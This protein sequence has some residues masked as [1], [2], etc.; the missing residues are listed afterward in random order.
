MIGVFLRGTH[1]SILAVALLHTMFNRSNNDEGLVAG[2]LEGD[3]RKLAGLLAVLILTATI[4]YI[5]RRLNRPAGTDRDSTI[6]TASHRHPV[7]RPVG[8][9]SA[10]L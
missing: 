3:G 10:K 9:R 4:A 8:S 7:R 6:R 1:G 2:L 5:S